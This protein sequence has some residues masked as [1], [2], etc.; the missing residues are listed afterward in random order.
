MQSVSVTRANQTRA[1]KIKSRA[2]ILAWL[3]FLAFGGLAFVIARDQAWMIN[4]DFFTFWGGARGL[5]DGANLYAPAEWARVTQANGSTWLPN[6]IFIYA[7]PTA[8]FFAPLAA[9][10]IEIASVVWVWL[11]EIFIALTVLIV[12]RSQHLSAVGKF[13]PL[14]GLGFAFF[15][16]V[17]L[18]L[19]MGQISALGL[20]IVA[21]TLALW[22]RGNWLRGGVMLGLAIIKPQPLIFFI[23]AISLWLI[24]NRRWR[25]VGGIALSFGVSTVA[26]LLLFPN[27]FPDWQSATVS[28]ISGVAARMPTVLGFVLDLFQD[29]SFGISIAAIAIAVSVALGLLSVVRQKNA[30]VFEIASALL[31]LSL[32][33]APYLWNYD[34]ILLLIPLTLALIWFD[35]RGAPFWLSASLPLLFDI[36]AWSLFALAALRGRDSPGVLL[37][38]L[39]GFYFW[40]AYKRNETR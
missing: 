33:V 4:R 10:P 37:P 30:D 23:P 16:P 35:Q 14:W 17:T 38:I 11:S 3:V 1:A 29:S 7:P 26:S 13:A 6:P 31:I 32:F 36:F 15:L 9:L 18:T 34:Q 39:I 27:F 2:Y 25:A 21:L 5:M 28:K 12:A 22:R 8:I 19:L 40:F 24:L 20:L